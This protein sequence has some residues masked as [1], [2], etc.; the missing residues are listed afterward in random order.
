MF[1]Q[2]TISLLDALRAELAD[3]QA[4]RIAAIDKLAVEQPEYLAKVLAMWDHAIG[5]QQAK[6]AREEQRMA[7]V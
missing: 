6:I 3:Y 7:T 4:K 1:D 5:V 2:S